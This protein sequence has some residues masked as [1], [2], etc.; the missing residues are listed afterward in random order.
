MHFSHIVHNPVT[1]IALE[2]S[3]AVI[4]AA[5]GEEFVYTFLATNTDALDQ[6]AFILPVLRAGLQAFDELL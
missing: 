2:F 1:S 4:F 5:I 3:E 6:N